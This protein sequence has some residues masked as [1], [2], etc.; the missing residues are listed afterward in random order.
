TCAFLRDGDADR[1]LDES[2][3][4]AL[5]S[6]FRARSAEGFRV[7]ALATR[8][9]VPK[10]D[11]DRVDEAQMTFRGFLVFQDPPKPDAERAVAQLRRLGIAIKV[12]SG[13][14]RFVTA[15]V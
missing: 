6:I 10:A 9:F 7:L 4:A 5:E 3:R 11:Y 2:N 12:I 1:P 15:H 13:D 14:N 8:R